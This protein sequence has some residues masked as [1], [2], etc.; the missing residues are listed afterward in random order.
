M[1]SWWSQVKKWRGALR[2]LRSPGELFLFLRVLSFAAAVP[3]L[4]RLRLPQLLAG[5][6]PYSLPVT[7]EPSRVRR[8]IHCV[9]AVL[10]LG[11][12]L[13]R[14]GCLTRSLTLYYFLRRAGLQVTL[15]FGMGQM[16]GKFVGHCWLMKEEEPFLERQ[17]PRPLFAETYRFPAELAGRLARPVEPGGMPTDDGR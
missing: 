11:S 4:L 10:R 9:E 1:R 2:Q 15:C 5:L 17:D 3:M 14:P 16:D 13:V 7:A 8:I 6:E 12:P